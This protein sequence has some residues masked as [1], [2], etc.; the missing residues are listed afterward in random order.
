MIVF[1]QAKKEEYYIHQ[2]SSNLTIL[3]IMKTDIK[4]YD[5]KKSSVDEW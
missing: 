3:N 5:F 1:I 4:N 2:M